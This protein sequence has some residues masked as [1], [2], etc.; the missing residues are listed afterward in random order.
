MLAHALY[1]SR[2]FQESVA[3]LEKGLAVL[4]AAPG[5]Q[6]AE[7]QPRFTFLL[8]ANCA[9]LRR[10]KESIRILEEAL[11][12]QP[13]LLPADQLTARLQLSFHY[14]AEANYHKANQT[15]ISLDRTDH[16][17]EQNL[18]ME[19]LLNH[20]LGE[21]LVQLELG[22]PDQALT[23]LKAIERRLHEQFPAAAATP[24][25]PAALLGGPYHAVLSF[26][27]FV[28]EIIADPA[29]ARTPDFAARVARIPAFLSEEREDL[30]VISFFAWL[31][32]RV[33]GKSYHEVLLQLAEG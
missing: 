5:R 12:A 24:E 23:R 7:L 32:A 9:F 2:R 17:L 33:L 11:A 1:R 3:Y 31:K 29:V 28:R 20:N 25:A 30:Q 13:P 16:W 21:M 22:N 18:G 10:N 14:F 15:L 27:G 8:A 19:W 4:A 6:L 26:L